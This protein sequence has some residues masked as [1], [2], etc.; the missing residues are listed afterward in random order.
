[1][2]VSSDQLKRQKCHRYL[3]D[4]HNSLWCRIDQSI[5]FLPGGIPSETVT[6]KIVEN[7]DKLEEAQKELGKYL[8]DELQLSR[9]I[10]KL[11]SKVNDNLCRVLNRME[12]DMQEKNLVR[13]ATDREEIMAFVQVTRRYVDS[14]SFSRHGQIWKQY[15]QTLNSVPKLVDAFLA[16]LFQNGKDL[17]DVLSG[18][19]QASLSDF[20]ETEVM[21]TIYNE[22]KQ[23]LDKGLSGNLKEL[24]I[25][26]DDMSCYED[27]I[28]ALRSLKRHLDSGLQDHVGKCIVFKMG[29]LMDSWLKKQGEVDRNFNFLGPN[30]ETNRILLAATLDKL[31]PSEQSW[32]P[33]S[34]FKNWYSGK[35][36]KSLCRKTEVSVLE[37]HS[38]GLSALRSRNF[39]VL[40]E[41]I[42][43]LCQ[44]DQQVHKH[45][46]NVDAKV[47]DLKT[48]A[49]DLFLDV[50]KQLKYALVGK[51]GFQYRSLFADFRS[52]VLK[53]ASVFDSKECKE[54]YSLT[55]LLFYEKLQKEVAQLKEELEVA[56]DSFD[57]SEIKLKVENVRVLGE[58]VADHYT[59]FF[60]E[61][62]KCDHIQ[63]DCWLKRIVE[64]CH[65]HFSA[66]RDFSKMKYYVR[67]GVVQSSSQD[68][69]RRVY[70][71]MAERYHRDKVAVQGEETNARFRAVHEAWEALENAN[72]SPPSIKAR[73][74][75]AMVRSIGK[76]LLEV[77]QEHLKHQKYETV[78]KLLSQ[79]SSI[80]DLE[81][82]VS[83]RLDSKRIQSS[84]TNLVK[85][86]VIQVRITVKSNWSERKYREL[87]EDID[88]LKRMEK[89]FKTVSIDSRLL[90][91]EGF[92][93]F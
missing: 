65:E 50:C 22:T 68:E 6:K 89:H 39:S 43:I 58:F 78:V 2:A 24:E 80:R 49:R 8:R 17:L 84:V 20:A 69:I 51:G 3:C 34:V 4:I 83:P 73:P 74:F 82:L 18:L 26:V 87:N 91:L 44:V 60:E 27:A 28:S 77:T 9:E 88:D 55:N 61:V 46:K 48:R 64:L 79:L 66:G 45:V 42:Q 71:I 12:T 92:N 53:V 25:R 38:K 35:E 33:L 75:E 52:F 81:D 57:F 14:T 70:K 37:L 7:V 59:L 29:E 76:R 86:H 85:E 62:N 54:A 31:D 1:L 21:T 67:L 32:F 72:Q 63:A 19:K 10:K 93:W 15:N 47:T 36:Y 5:N 13:L 56:T 30:A 16:S 11:R 40:E 41:Y 23:R 90:C